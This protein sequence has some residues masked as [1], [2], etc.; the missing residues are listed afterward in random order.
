MAQLALPAL[1][2]LNWSKIRALAKERAVAAPA[3]EVVAAALPLLDA[4][5]APHRMLAVYL[6]GYTAGAQPE[7]LAVLRERAAPDA[8]WEVQEAL[9]QAFDAACAA[10]GYEAALPLIDDWLAGAHP[11]TRRAVS[12]GLRP[13]TAKA[14]P[15]FARHPEEAIRRL[16]ALRRD[17][18]EYVRHSA[19][20]ALRDIRRAHGT[21]VDAE[22]AT[23]Y[24]ADPREAYTYARVLK[25]QR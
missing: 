18:S 3:A 24:L 21:L 5:D 12:E 7:N 14:R 6:L 13:W 8:S 11:H 17:D 4:P 25:A 23:W 10:R 9:A 20:N 16:A 2:G 15:Y 22:T 1:N 19:G